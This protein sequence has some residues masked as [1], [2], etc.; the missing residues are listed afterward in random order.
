MVFNYVTLELINDCIFD[1]VTII[2]KRRQKKILF[3][4]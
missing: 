3:L 4:S 1:V 2:E